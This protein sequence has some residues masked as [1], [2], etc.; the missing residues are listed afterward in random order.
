M[1]ENAISSLKSSLAESNVTENLAESAKP[2]PPRKMNQQS[3]RKLR[4]ALFLPLTMAIGEVVYK[5]MLWLFQNVNEDYQW[6][7]A[8]VLVIAREVNTLVLS[9]V[10]HK[11]TGKDDD[12][13]VEILSAHYAAIKHILFW[14]Q[15]SVSVII[16]RIFSFKE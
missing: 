14:F 4:T 13:L 15:M 11:I 5:G 10:G 16:D 1:S 8:F 7:L 6:T 3:K 2:P 12:L 9:W